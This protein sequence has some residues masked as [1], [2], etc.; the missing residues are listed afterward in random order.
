[1]HHG[2]QAIASVRFLE[3]LALSICI[4]CTC[5]SKQHI[6]CFVDKRLQRIKESYENSLITLLMK[7]KTQNIYGKIQ[8][9]NH[10]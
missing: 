10:L 5:G 9:V 2:K 3:A 6:I 7:I 1:M 8:N 4:T